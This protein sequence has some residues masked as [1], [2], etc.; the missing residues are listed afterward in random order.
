M[1]WFT[2]R[3]SIA[4]MYPRSTLVESTRY[5]NMPTADAYF[6]WSCLQ[7][8]SLALRCSMFRP[9]RYGMFAVRL[10]CGAM[11]STKRRAKNGCYICSPPFGRGLTEQPRRRRTCPKSLAWYF[12]RR[13]AS[14]A[15]NAVMISAATQKSSTVTAMN[16]RFSLISLV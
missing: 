15:R 12:C 2:D 5:R 9:A 13:S 6:G 14:T 8:G 4:V 7:V 16:T 3:A 11:S 1:A 10:S